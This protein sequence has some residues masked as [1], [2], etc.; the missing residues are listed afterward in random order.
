LKPHS[1]GSI[2]GQFK[3]VCT[4]RIRAAG[5][6]DFAWQPRFYDHIIRSD[7]S[8][9]EIR[10]YIVHNALK[11]ESDRENLANLRI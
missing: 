10:E 7:K 5:F 4:K 1:L 11:W 3:S 8:L 9:E 6:P 2:I